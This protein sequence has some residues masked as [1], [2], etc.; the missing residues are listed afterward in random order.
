MKNSGQYPRPRTP[1]SPDRLA[2]PICPSFRGPSE[3]VAVQSENL[4]LAR[5]ADQRHRA[6]DTQA[7]TKQRQKTGTET[8]RETRCGD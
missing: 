6:T 5:R 7:G 4:S 1:V 2:D 3:G 8:Q